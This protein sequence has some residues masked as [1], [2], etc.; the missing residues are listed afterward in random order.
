[1]IF[2]GQYHVTTTCESV[3][4]KEGSEHNAGML[5]VLSRWKW[6]LVSRHDTH[7][8][9]HLRVS[10]TI[11]LVQFNHN[12]HNINNANT[13]LGPEEEKNED[14]VLTRI[15]RLDCFVRNQSRL[16]QI[17]SSLFQP[18]SLNRSGDGLEAWTSE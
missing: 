10:R 2:K 9:E 13:T 7:L 12:N 6:A 15:H 4:D 5:N 1:M 8:R 16:D 18:E 11:H 14:Q 17:V 3:L